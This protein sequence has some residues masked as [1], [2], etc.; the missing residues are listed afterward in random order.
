MAQYDG[1]IRI[2]TGI[3]EKGFKAGSKELESGAR[4]L[5][6]S[7]SDSLGDGAKIA[8]QKQTDAFVKLN[9]QY[10]AQEQ[11]VKEI[12]SR[13]HDMQ[14][15][16]IETAE[17]KEL[18]KDLDKAKV[19]LD[20]LYDRRD[21]YVELGKKVP[22]KLDLDISDAE[23][24]IRLLEGDIKKL[25][26]TNKAY[27]PV[28]T[29]KVQQELAAA[30]QK[31]MQIYTALQTSADAISQKTSE[32]I[33]KEDI[34]REK[35]AAEV[36]EE[37]RLEQ[38]RV[39]AV[40]SNDQII[41]KVERLR[42]LE[43]EIADLK[44][45][46]IAEGYADYD[47]RIQ[48]AARLR[49][50]I[51]EYNNELTKTPEKFKK[52]RKSA[53]KAFTAV[54]SGTKKSSGLLS[55]FASRLKGLALSLL[56][57]NWISKAFNAMISGMKQGF[58]NFMN[59]SDDFANSVQDIKNAMSTL[60]N[61]FAAAFAPIVQMIIPWLT[62]LVSA[63]ST[64]M[65]YIAQFIAI[66]G[67]KSTFVR[68]KQ[69]QDSYNKSL[70]GTAAAAKKA[71]GALAKFDDL[72]VLQK[73]EDDTTG[74]AGGA[75]GDMF[76]E[77]P[78][79][80]KFKDWLDGILEKLKPILD[81][82]NK[83]K[84]IF[85]EGFWDGLGDW[86]YRLDIIKNSLS[87][88][89]DS[90][91]EIWTDPEV[92]S[93]AD[94]WAQSVAYMLGSVVGSM[95]SIG[96]TIAANLLGGIAKY[97]EENKGRIKEYLISMF[98][99]G[100]ELN[101]TIAKLSQSI[102]YIFEA[103]AS[104]EGISLTSNLFGI[105]LDTLMGI[106]EIAL[107]V[108]NDVLNI[109]AQPVIDNAEGF[110]TALEG[111]LGFLSSITG[112]IK[113]GIDDTFDKLNKVY[114][115]HFKPFFDS[116]A[117]GLSQLV[118]HFLKFWNGN[119]QPIL[120]QWAEGFDNLWTGHIQ[121]LLD[122]VSEFLGKISDLLKALWENILQPLIEWIIDNV[123]PR[124]LPI[125][126]AMW[127][128]IVELVGYIA[129]MASDVI[130]ILSGIIDF[131]TGIFSGDWEK[132][133]NGILESTEGFIGYLKD[134]LEGGIALILDFIVV[135]LEEFAAFLPEMGQ[136]IVQGLID[137]IL[138]FKDKAVESISEIATGIIDK[139]KNML[140]IHSPSTEMKEQGEYTIEGLIEGLESK[141]GYV[142]E[143]WTKLKENTISILQS[144]SDWISNFGLNISDGL[145]ATLQGIQEQ[146]TLAWTSLYESTV[147]TW[148]M[149][150]EYFTE[151][152]LLFIE[153]LTET[154]ETILLLFIENFEQVKIL[155]EEFITFLNEIFLI[156][157]IGIWTM[158]GEQYQ[159][160][161]DLLTALTK[162]LQ[163]MLTL[164]MKQ[165]EI[166]INTMWKK[167]W[168]NAKNIFTEFKGKVQEISDVV[169][170][171]VQS[172]FEFVMGLV[173]EMLAAI[174]SV[175]TA[176]SSISGG[177]SGGGGGAPFSAR[178]VAP[179]INSYSTQNFSAFMDAIPHLASGSV[180]RGG[181][182]FMAVLG[183][184][185]VGQTNVE[186]PAGLIKDMARQGIRE[187]LAALNL[188]GGIGQARVVLN[189]NGTDVGEAILDD[190][191]SVMQRRG[192]DV[193]VL[194]VT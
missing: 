148:T 39:N 171:I 127:N 117:N 112:T 140:G 71:Y 95:A 111:I 58:T 4:S 82:F 172:L 80:S 70:G 128:M 2:G 31:Q 57:F 87:S 121:P 120:D 145:V 93:A 86:E 139:F 101:Y 75:A 104:P 181:N 167:S 27:V 142:S 68:A 185:K 162:T 73:K 105:I 151:F 102:A 124:I 83:L 88:I 38:I 157:W 72:D 155:F 19:S 50:D 11:K 1:S 115:T 134:S 62:K 107:K 74:G 132:V 174:E 22:P 15:Q 63:I 12:A 77:V 152:W 169:R 49:Q 94:N 92:L 106:S 90:L 51:R 123:L 5:A 45:A 53:N 18:S 14:R 54:A 98:D 109:F 32:R 184:Q 147:E 188:G 91:I 41:A 191:F 131:L 156:S 43:Q 34:V 153:S 146:F 30:E 52:M 55:T 168:E 192:Y 48:E 110:K 113:Q 99:I 20:R 150:Q 60:G 78:V 108:S 21:A 194:G 190:L 137:G 97:L 89:K 175:G 118:G 180:I 59:Y 46:G 166:L 79:D 42:K 193:D 138:S 40:A 64:A 100:A 37:E 161:H 133:F 35:I 135:K 129:D 154:W 130:D 13:L 17:F 103:F 182:P 187:E 189:V 61:Q 56:I 143:I 9:Q 177:S 149:I 126:E 85:M 24:K 119:V 23:R 170:E 10:A 144:M 165:I 29:T 76:E 141:A 6:K 66:L 81:Y 158:A 26:L 3:D 36:A 186:A 116:V 47:N 183:D 125:F 44:A 160:Y 7:V 84:D 178:S 67:G 163:E 25:K 179:A 164:F 8:L 136:N 16:K 28:D 69:V 65:T 122:N 159:T 176:A 33:A 96:L 114:D 173:S